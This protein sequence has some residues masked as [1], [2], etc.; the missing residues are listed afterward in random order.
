MVMHAQTLRESLAAIAKVSY[1]RGEVLKREKKRGIEREG[2]VLIL[3]GY[4]QV[5]LFLQA[6]ASHQ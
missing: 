6:T 5:S 1:V 2:E 4:L 3:S